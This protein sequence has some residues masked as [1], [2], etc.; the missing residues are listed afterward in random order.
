MFPLFISLWALWVV[1]KVPFE[2]LCPLSQGKHRNRT[3]LPTLGQR[4]KRTGS[5]K[6]VEGEALNQES[7]VQDQLCHPLAPRTWAIDLP[8]PSLSLLCC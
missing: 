5:G 3:A 4:K 7:W 1:S 2:N 8:S 6:G